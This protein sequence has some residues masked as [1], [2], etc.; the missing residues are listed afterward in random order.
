MRK[1]LKTMVFTQETGGRWI[2]GGALPYIY[3]Y[4]CT[5]FMGVLCLDPY[6]R[7]SLPL[8][9]AG[10]APAMLAG[11]LPQEAWAGRARAKLGSPST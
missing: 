10:L 1:L 11:P 7:T 5:P 8:P 4:I 6:I 9:A 2:E 3:I